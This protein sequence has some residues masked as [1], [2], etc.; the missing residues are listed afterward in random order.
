MLTCTY[1]IAHSNG[2]LGNTEKKHK[3]TTVKAVMSTGYI[4]Y[5]QLAL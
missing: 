1:K 4:I 3:I 2:Y 5:Q